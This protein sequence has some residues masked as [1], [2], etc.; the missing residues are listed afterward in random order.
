MMTNFP[1]VLEWY[2]KEIES[3]SPDDIQ[4]YAQK[5]LAPPYLH[6]YNVTTEVCVKKEGAA[7]VEKY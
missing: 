5:D 7:S 6:F 2:K 3:Y 1:R 4:I